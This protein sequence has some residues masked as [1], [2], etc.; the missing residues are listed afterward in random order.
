MRF[1]DW[2]SRNTGNGAVSALKYRHNRRLGRQNGAGGKL[3]PN[4]PP[5]DTA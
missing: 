1:R 5:A 3:L 2:R 4:P